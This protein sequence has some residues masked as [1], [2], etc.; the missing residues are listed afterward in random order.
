MRMEPP[1]SVPSASA[2][3][4]SATAPPLPPDEPPVFLAVLNGLREG[5]KR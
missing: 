2:T 1:P 5:P 3:S 4:P